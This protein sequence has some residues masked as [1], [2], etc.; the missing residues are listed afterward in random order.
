MVVLAVAL[1]TPDMSDAGR[2]PH[3]APKSRPGKSRAPSGTRPSINGGAQKSPNRP[4]VTP[5]SSGN[6]APS[7]DTA[8]K[9]VGDR[10]NVG[11]KVNV[12]K[13]RKDV[14]INVDNSV[15]INNRRNTVVRP[16]GRPYARPP[17]VYGGR[18]YYCHTAYFYHP[19]RPY[20]WGPAWHP[21][22]F[23]VA[24]LAATAII[25]TV[26]N[27]KYHYDQGVYYVESNGGYVA[28]AA[29]VGATVPS[30]PEGSQT[31]VVNETT[32]NYYYGGTYY[33]KSGSGYTV[34]APTAGTIVENLP[35]G[36][37][38]VR[39]GDITYTKVGETYYQPI[40]KDGK[41]MYEVVQVEE[42]E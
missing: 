21:W 42:G 19:Y 31:V 38:E 39:V 37:E 2:M 1:A 10:T 28:T 41:D 14:N 18:R 22:G 15:H 26:E 33:E 6:R 24:A 27:Q 13:S 32:N 3:S 12:D 29:P 4:A 35:E 17:Y 9:N 25:V 20:Y 40:Q 11:N 23:F 5:P 8:G 7:R 36:G 16:A 30:I 34:V